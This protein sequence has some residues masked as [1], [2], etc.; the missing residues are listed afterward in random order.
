MGGKMM[1]NRLQQL[2]QEFERGQK[3][4]EILDHKRRDLRDTLLRISGA[5]QVVEELLEQQKAS[6]PDVENTELPE[7]PRIVAR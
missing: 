5:M 7:K 3:Q 4:L 1:Q 6:Q 2:K